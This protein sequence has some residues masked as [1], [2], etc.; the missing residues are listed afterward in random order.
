MLVLLQK[1]VAVTELGVVLGS[2]RL[3]AFGILKRILQGEGAGRMGN[4][5]GGMGLPEAPCDGDESSTR[6]SSIGEPTLNPCSEEAVIWSSRFLG[7]GAEDPLP[8]RDP[9]VEFGLLRLE[10]LLDGED[11]GLIW[12]RLAALDVLTIPTSRAIPVSKENFQDNW[13]RYSSSDILRFFNLVNVILDS[14]LRLSFPELIV[15]LEVVEII[16]DLLPD[17]KLADAIRP[18]GIFS[19]TCLSSVT[20]TTHPHRDI[21]GATVRKIESSVKL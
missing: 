12:P 7:H 5:A 11:V 20:V 18:S 14:K 4:G 17:Q 21:S 3:L 15:Q 8:L 9:E 2:L 16:L 10:S 13:T 6:H 19:F 1:V